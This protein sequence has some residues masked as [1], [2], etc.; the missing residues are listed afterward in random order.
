MVTEWLDTRICVHGAPKI[1]HTDNGSCFT[2]KDFQTWAEAK[3]IKIVHGRALHPQSQGAVEKKN[4]DSKSKLSKI[5]HELR[6]HGTSWAGY[7][8]AVVRRMN[9]VHSTAIGMA[10]DEVNLAA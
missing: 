5:I 6:N 2:S 8:P 1:L 7:L 4:R 3:N 10:P 9:A